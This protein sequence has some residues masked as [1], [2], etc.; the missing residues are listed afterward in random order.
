MISVWLLLV[1]TG[2]LFITSG[3]FKEELNTPKDYLVIISITILLLYCFTSR[4]RLLR[5]KESFN[6]R[7]METGLI[8]ICTL[9]T[10]HGFLQYCG[11]LPSNHVSFPITGAFENPAGFAAAQAALFPFVFSKCL[12]DSYG[13]TFRLFAVLVSLMCFISVI[14]SGS[15]A[16]F[17]ALFSVVVVVSSFNDSVSSFFKRYRWSWLLLLL[18]TV[19]SFVVLYYI[20]K[21][22]ADGRLFIWSR[23]FDLIKER[24]L[25]GYGPFGFHHCY[26]AAQAD[27]FRT[28]L[29]SPFVMIA[30]N[31]TH[32]FNEYI[33]LT[34]N[35]GLTGLLVAIILLAWIVSVLLKANMKI[36]VQGL[37]FIS[38]LFILCQFSYPFRYAIVW[39]LAFVAIVP[40]IIK[41]R[42][43]SIRI[44]T[45]VMAIVS[46]LSLFFLVITLKNMYYDMKWAEI[47]KRSIVGLADRMIK[48]YEGLELVK[49][50]DPLF[51][52]NYAAE[53]N[54]LGD[55][56]KSV[57]LTRRCAERWDDY[58]VQIML[59]SNYAYLHDKDNAVKSFDQ[60]SCMIPCRFEP[61]YGKMTVY[62]NCNDTINALRMANDIVE[63]PIKV[64]SGRVSFIVE[65]A[66]QVL[67]K[68]D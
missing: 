9:V 18:M 33:L 27:Y 49:K 50:K 68:Y 30:D 63:K 28:H 41:P 24:P 29:E 47:S 59:A 53:L 31:V 14:L 25:L 16:G 12:D 10:I 1:I 5:L 40:A 32:P 61:L 48:H 23:C 39:L 15:R 19:S 45:P 17:L 34:V 60:A 22:S 8:V 65:Y 37:S 62:V 7:I 6:S 66:R 58:D 2:G 54:V 56:Q 38:S 3:L 55:Y 42:N 57:D 13:K 26:M 64:R 4:K 44:A 51:L 43:Q 52:Y 21:D 35:Y 20:K 46:S 36:K 67:D 11:L